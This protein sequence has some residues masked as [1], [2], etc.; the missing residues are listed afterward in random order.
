[1]SL[2]I[3]ESDSTFLVVDP[4]DLDCPVI[5]AYPT[6][7]EAESFLEYIGQVP[8]DIDPTSHTETQ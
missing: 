7:A 2:Q 8:P 1:M 5:D 3:V 6:R 4:S